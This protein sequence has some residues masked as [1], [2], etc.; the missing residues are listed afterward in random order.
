MSD[1]SSKFVQFKK[2]GSGLYGDVFQAHQVNLNRSVALKVIKI[3]RINMATA[4]EHALVLAQ[5]RHENVVI[6]YDLETVRIPGYAE[7]VEAVVMEWLEGVT[8]GDRLKGGGIELGEVVR[9]GNA[10]LSGLQHMHS[11]NVFHGDLHPGNVIISSEFVKIIDVTAAQSESIARYSTMG[12]ETR[13]RADISATSWLIRS[14]LY[15]CPADLSTLQEAINA[16]PGVR[17]LGDLVHFMGRVE[18][19]MRSCP[20]SSVSPS[21]SPSF[22]SGLGLRPLDIAALKALGDHVIDEKH[23]AVAISIPMIVEELVHQGGS[24]EAALDSIEILGDQSFFREYHGRHTRNVQLSLS[25][26]EYYLQAFYPQREEAFKSVMRS[27]IQDRQR[28]HRLIQAYT[29]L[30]GALVMHVLLLLEADKSLVLS[31]TSSGFNVVEISAK[32]RRAAGES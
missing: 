21:S 26:F 31:K 3:D 23:N 29:R 32:L 13:K 14:M 12:A 15:Q 25:G 17:S 2:H 18:L 5:L 11:K 28:S 4:K 24:Q 22:L 20:S 27:I 10:V 7:P 9:I 6:V 30:S 16:L 8:L 1:A 19:L